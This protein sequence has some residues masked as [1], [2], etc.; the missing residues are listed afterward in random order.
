MAVILEVW[1]LE[2]WMLEVWMLE[3]WMLLSASLGLAQVWSHVRFPSATDVVMNVAG[4][5]AGALIR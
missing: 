4:S 2:V 5:V 3:V 1:M